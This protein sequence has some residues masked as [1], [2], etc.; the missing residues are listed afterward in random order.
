MSCDFV[1]SPIFFDYRLWASAALKVSLVIGGA[2]AVTL[3]GL[4]FQ[5]QGLRDTAN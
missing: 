3:D 5:S 2:I 1:G 4:Q